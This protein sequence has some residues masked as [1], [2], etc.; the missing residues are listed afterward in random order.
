MF[1]NETGWA[2]AI[3]PHG[4]VVGYK[5]DGPKFDSAL[6]QILFFKSCG[7]WTLFSDFAHS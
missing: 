3:W 7:V 5:A 6:A 2:I 4:E 1:V